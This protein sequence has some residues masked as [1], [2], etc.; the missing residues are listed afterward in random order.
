MEGREKQRR[1]CCEGEQRQLKK[2]RIRT[3]AVGGGPRT[4]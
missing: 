1:D 4:G 3:G 2:S